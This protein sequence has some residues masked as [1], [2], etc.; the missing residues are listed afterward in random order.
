MD[1][2]NRTEKLNPTVMFEALDGGEH[3]IGTNFGDE[4]IGDY[5]SE[6]CG[7]VVEPPKES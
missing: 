1:G 7:H 5:K 6:D 3:F 4:Q 2:I